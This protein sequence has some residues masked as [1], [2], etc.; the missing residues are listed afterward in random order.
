MLRISK[1]R[2]G[3]SFVTAWYALEP[4][5]EPGVIQYKEALFQ[6][7]GAAKTVEFETLVSD[8][9]KT[10]EEILE[11]FSKNCRY[12]IRRA[13]KEE[14]EVTVLAGKLLTRKEIAEFCNFFTEFWASKGV[15]YTDAKKLEEEIAAYAAK[16]GFVLTSASIHGK[17]LVYHTYIVDGERARLYHS[18]SLYRQDT[19]MPHGLTGMVNR[20]LHKEDMLYFKNEGKT[21]YDWGGAGRN[22]EVANITK[23]KE[24]FG[25]TPVTYYDFTQVNGLKARLFVWLSDW[26]HRFRRQP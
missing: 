9:A 21:F 11:K 4:L 7:A 15:E 18:A 17:K 25:G 20:H 23:F 14:I 16:D 22:K 12:E 8:L 3:I 19:E 10:Q 24:S 6:K 2:H 13:A 1:K 26:K 5:K